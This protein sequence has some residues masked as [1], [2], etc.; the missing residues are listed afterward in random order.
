MLRLVSDWLDLLLASVS[1]ACTSAGVC[2]MDLRFSCV[3]WTCTSCWR[4]AVPA[5]RLRR[6][7]PRDVSY[8]GL[9]LRRAC[10]GPGLWLGSDMLDLPFGWSELDLHF[11]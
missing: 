10:A 1:R 4:Q 7:L 11:G 5:L 9:V 2:M 6:E 8:A 3:Q